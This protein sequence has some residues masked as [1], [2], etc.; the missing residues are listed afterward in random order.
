MDSTRRLL[1]YANA[2]NDIPTPPSRYTESQMQQTNLNLMLPDEEGWEDGRT[3]VGDA[4]HP[5]ILGER[6]RVIASTPSQTLPAST[7]THLHQ[8]PNHKIHKSISQHRGHLDLGG[9]ME[10]GGTENREGAPTRST[11]HRS[12]LSNLASSISS[13]GSGS[14]TCLRMPTEATSAR[15]P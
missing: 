13:S 9:R 15:P 5:H 11:S 1:F 2:K 3:K 4:F 7:F 12:P 8:R 6:T 14:W 10:G